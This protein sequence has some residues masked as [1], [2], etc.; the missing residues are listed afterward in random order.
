MK[1][2]RV[3]STVYP[4]R[5]LAMGQR[6]TSKRRTG[7]SQG[8]STLVSARDQP[9]RL[10]VKPT[11]TSNGGASAWLVGAVFFTLSFF[12]PSSHRLFFP[13][14]SL[15]LC[16]RVW[17][18]LLLLLLLLFLLLFSCCLTSTETIRRIR[19][20]EPLTVT[21]TFTQLLSCCFSPRKPSGLLGTGSP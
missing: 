10:P 14:L 15:S 8:V 21:S 1:T 11:S 5:R 20:G 18:F 7:R 3:I 19:D 16:E 17:T 12:F 13:P 9:H 4:L 6:W 2:R